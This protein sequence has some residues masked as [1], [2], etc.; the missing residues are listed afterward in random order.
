MKEVIISIIGTQSLEEG[1]ESIEL[2]TDGHYSFDNGKSILTYMES[3]ITG[4]DGTKTTF[5]V[6]SDLVTMIREGTVNSQMTFEKGKKHFF[7]YETPYGA[8]TLGVNTHRLK[9][10]FGEHGGNMELEYALDI[11]NMRLGIN[12][13]K[14]NVKEA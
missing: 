1:L 12:A 14:I 5:E 9:T 2:V 10:G 11:D 3:E 6:G 7:M 4:M 8:A 13:F